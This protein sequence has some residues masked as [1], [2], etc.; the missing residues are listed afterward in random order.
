[1]VSSNVSLAELG[2]AEQVFAKMVNSQ[3]NRV[4]QELLKLEQ[5]LKA[6]MVDGNALREFRKAVDQVRQTSWAVQQKL[7]ETDEQKA[8]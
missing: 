3:L 2:D 7:Q 6:G 5:L 8:G 4:T 1:M